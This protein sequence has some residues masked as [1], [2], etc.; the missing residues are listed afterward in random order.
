MTPAWTLS[1]HARDRSSARALPPGVADLIL[2]YGEARDAGDGARKHALSR[3]SFRQIKR[4]F[5]REFAKALGKYRCAY[6][7]AAADRVI[8]V[9]WCKQ[10]LFH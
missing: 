7:V 2:T 10:P 3:Q 9:A 8:T 6:V 1:S 5:G 4:D